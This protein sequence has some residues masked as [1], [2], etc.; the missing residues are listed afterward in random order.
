MVS[1]VVDLTEEMQARRRADLAHARLLDAIESL[2]AA[3]YLYD[4]EE[5]LVLWNSGVRDLFPDLHRR[6][7]PGMPFEEVL[8][9]GGVIVADAEGRLEPWIAERLRRFRQNPGPYEQKLADGR[10]LQGLDR[11]TA[12][13]GTVSLR[14]DISAVKQREQELLQA[15]KM[16]AL[17]Q[18]TGGIAHDFN[19]LLTVILGN[20]EMLLLSG[21]EGAEGGAAR[22][23]A[24]AGQRAGAL[25]RRLLAFARRQQ[26]HVEELSLERMVE[27]MEPLIRRTLGE[28]I[29][30]DIRRGA[31]LWPVLTDPA[32]VENALLNLAVNARDA[33]PK[34]GRLTI[35]TENVHLEAGAAGSSFPPEPGDY[36]MLAVTD[37]GVGMSKEVM[38]RALEPFFTTKGVGKGTGLGLSMV[39]G[40]VTQSGGHLAM[41]SEPG[42]GT[43]IRLYLPRHTGPG[44]APAAR[45][46]DTD[47]L[48][49]GSGTVLVVEDDALVRANAVKQLKSLGYGVL[50]ASDGP[51][52]LNVLMQSE[53]VD[54]LFT[55]IVIPGGLSGHELAAKA[56]ALWPRLAVVFTTGYAAEAPASVEGPAASTAF[57]PKPYLRPELA[58]T[59]RAVLDS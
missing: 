59:L 47:P 8:R 14:F 35:A 22:M 16:E 9:H 6:L 31:D 17:G 55:D 2:P 54:V 5:R 33:M 43:T 45:T 36:V 28:H 51:G 29:A 18:L 58:R 42:R 32:Q 19:N 37:T 30:I 1:I 49:R 12:D 13:G 24:E 53:P 40:F 57:L 44:S 23:I 25:T 7:R 50:E 10:W 38:A 27:G 26:L 11:R 34:G 3:F 15:Q 4:A 41:D 21:L 20:A 52:A 39:Y 48:P 56:R 46:A